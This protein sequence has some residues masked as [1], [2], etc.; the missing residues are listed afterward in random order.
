MKTSKLHFTRRQA[1]AKL[2]MAAGSAILAQGMAA[3]RPAGY[4]PILAAESYIWLEEFQAS[5]QTLADGIPEMCE[6]FHR[7]GFE[8]VELDED[9][10]VDK[11]RAET[12]EQL[13]RNQLRLLSVY[14]NSVMHTPDVAEKSIARIVAL[15]RSLKSTG[16][17]AI[18]TDPLP[19]PDHQP[20]SEAELALQSRSLNALASQLQTLGIRLIVHHHTP[21]LADNAREWRYELAHTDPRLVLCCVDVDWAVRGRQQPLLFIKACGN[22]LASLHLRNDK[23]GVWMEDFGPGDI[24]YHPI[25][26]YLRGINYQGFLIVELAYE[27]KT[28][29]T[30]PLAE[31]LLRSRL[32]AQKVFEL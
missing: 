19:R 21:E 9:F 13:T 32:Y 30:R 27:R 2:G 14:A 3:A 5:K 11:L 16:F 20:K 29:V 7:A 17:Q 22:R 18:I 26:R 6:G 31:D 15:A 25:A 28:R 10:L 23:N 12:L 24:D 8:N 4:R 1:M